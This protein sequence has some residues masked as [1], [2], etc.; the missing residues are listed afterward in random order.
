MSEIMSPQQTNENTLCFSGHRFIASSVTPRLERIL[1]VKVA[2]AYDHGYRHFY[3]GGA[4]GFDTMAARAVL[5][6]R[7]NHED[8]CLHI[9]VPC[10]TQSDQWNADQRN[11]YN[12]VLSAADEVHVLSDHYYNGCMDIRNRYMVDH[13]SL[14]ICWLTNFHRSGT[15]ATVRYAMKQNITVVNLAMNI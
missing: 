4:L 6:L 15:M 13:S 12:R 8:V 9:A 14:C 10:S 11:E 7:Q 2:E 5:E 1:A 3:C